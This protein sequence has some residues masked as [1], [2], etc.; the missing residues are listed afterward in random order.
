[1]NN[2][3]TERLITIVSLIGF[4][5]AAKTALTGP[6]WMHRMIIHLAIC[7]IHIPVLHISVVCVVQLLMLLRGSSCE[8][9]VTAEETVI[10]VRRDAGLHTHCMSVFSEFKGLF[11]CREV[12]I[13]QATQHTN[14]YRKTRVRCAYVW[15]LLSCISAF[16]RIL[17]RPDLSESKRGKT[18]V[19]LMLSTFIAVVLTLNALW[20]NRY[21]EVI[22]TNRIVTDV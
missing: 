17:Y 7:C 19:Q 12:N 4:P 8:D 21:K 6:R 18:K 22:L 20:R 10:I 5:W 14:Q 2:S 16:H 1:M 13:C 11:K 9:S 3:Y 15:G